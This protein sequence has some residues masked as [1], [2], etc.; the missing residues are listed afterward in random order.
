MSLPRLPLLLSFGTPGRVLFSSS[1]N[2]DAIVTAAWLFIVELLQS[3]YWW[4]KVPFL[5]RKI[6]MSRQP[7]VVAGVGDKDL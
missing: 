7:A 5:C 6:L 2:L 3:T 1:P 4:T